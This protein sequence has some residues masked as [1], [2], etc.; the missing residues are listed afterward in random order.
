M[1]LTHICPRFKES[2]GGGEPVLF[3]LFGQLCNLGFENTVCTY[4]FPLAMRS[5]LDSRIVLKELPK[6]FNRSFVNVLVSGF[7]DLFCSVFLTINTS[8]VTD[9]VCFHT[10]SVIP[11]LFFYRLFGG[12]KP[13]LYFCFQPPRFAYDTTQETARA[14]GLIGL[15]VPLFKAVYRPFDK[16]TVR[17]ADIVATFSHDYRRWIEGI[18]HITGVTV[19]PPGVER[20]KTLPR[21]P[22]HIMGPLSQSKAKTLLFVGKLVTWKN[23]DRL[24]NIT[25][26]VRMKFPSVR[27]L[28]VGDGPC[29]ASLRQQATDMRLED[30]VIFCGYVSGDEV[31]SYCA[32]ADLLVLLEQNASFGLSLIE[33]NAMG[34]PVMAFEGG[35]PSDIIEDARNGFLLPK[36]S[37]DEDIA[38]LICGYFGDD[39]KEKAMRSE[40]LGVAAK[41]TWPHFAEAF[42]KAV[43]ELTGKLSP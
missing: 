42:G 15:L 7:Y 35:G 4:N 26:L 21:L 14:G 37:T 34:L 24:I 20:P 25:A 1:H 5:L 9:V 11:A 31:F 39:E 8:K 10:E 29:M 3:H 43:L 6:I 27:L 33:A 12:T 19:F 38:E 28:I 40:A 32:L 16:T 13:A 18:Y 2:H 22:E 23:V 17:R 36:D 30:R 41:F